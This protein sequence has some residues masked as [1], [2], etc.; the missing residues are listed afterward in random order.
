MSSVH[1]SSV[2]TVKDLCAFQNNH[3]HGKN[4]QSL[5]DESW[6]W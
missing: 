2:L 4:N 5:E 1:S 6:G 3:A